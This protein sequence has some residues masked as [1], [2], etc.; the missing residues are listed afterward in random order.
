M[1]LK[2]FFTIIFSRVVYSAL[3][4][5]L[6]LGALLFVF[7]FFKEQFVWFYAFCVLLSIAAGLHVLN[8][9]MNP[10]Y[11][12]AW[13]VPILLFPI[14][15]GFLYL[16]Y[17]KARMT[18]SNRR[19]MAKV[20]ERYRT[21]MS[22]VPGSAP[23]LETESPD[24]AIH[25]KYISTVAS[26]P[27]Y[28]HTFT[29]YFPTGEAYFAALK[30]ELEKAQRF[31]FLEY[32]IV[33]DGVMWGDILDI[34][35][36]KAQ[37]GVDVRMMYDDLGCVFTLPRSY[38]KTLEKLGIKACVFHRFNSVLDSRFNARDHRKICVVDG[39]VGITGGI[40]L[41]DEY[42]NVY[43]KHGHWKDSGVLLRGRAVWSLTVMF[44]TMWDY[45]RKEQAD[46]SMYLPGMEP[47]A[48]TGA[49]G[50][51]Q[52]YTDVPIDDE[53]VGE[54]VYLNLINRAQR[55]VY[56]TT[57]YLIIDN[58]LLT[59]LRTAAKSGVDV[60]IIT[61]GVPDKRLVYAVTRSNYEPLLTSGVR[62]YEYTPGFMHAKNFV[63]DDR[64]GIVGTINLD[65][66]SLYLH[67]ECAV[68]MYGTASV[69]QIKQDFTDTLDSC[70]E[71]TAATLPKRNIFQCIW[72]AAL[73]AFAPLL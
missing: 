36:R 63:C 12:L 32:F 56:I 54:T 33:E 42:I 58:E 69:P 35:V 10:A 62:I 25:A 13:I 37:Q 26:V 30:E 34:L 21:A 68:W 73:R 49:T 27:P 53:A 61:P 29:E 7:C 19:S 4:I 2:R 48:D 46:F 24:A 14:F 51:A 18:R 8:R 38:D 57:P 22:L 52:P 1:I 39:N 71:I 44:L 45:Y 72:L 59:A 50:Y 16:L 6:Q 70:L 67:Y 20:M 40:N 9:D 66:R 47:A 43:P 41:A 65:Y 31:I 17:G 3:F 15:G 23:E 28:R 60:R 64:Y 5:L 11:K 55:Y